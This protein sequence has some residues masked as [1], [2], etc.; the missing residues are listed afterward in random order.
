M[1][2]SHTTYEITSIAAPSGT[3]AT[4]RRRARL[5]RDPQHR[6]TPTPIRPV[7]ATV[8]ASTNDALI[9][10]HP[11]LLAGLGP[12]L[13]ATRVRRTHHNDQTVPAVDP[14]HP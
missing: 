11:A 6:T 12:T 7:A 10:P 4:N 13:P 5:Q 3:A 2:T 1:V 9:Q 14:K 8:F